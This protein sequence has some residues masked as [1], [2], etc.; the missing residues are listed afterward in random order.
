MVPRKTMP[1]ENYRVIVHPPYFD[2]QW[3]C[4]WAIFDENV[5]WHA[6]SKEAALDR[7]QQQFQE[8]EAVVYKD[9]DLTARTRARILTGGFSIQVTTEWLSHSSIPT[10]TSKS[11]S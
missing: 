11:S 5:F 6:P 8:T 4:L 10:P 3:A 2:D 1:S 9:A 7:L